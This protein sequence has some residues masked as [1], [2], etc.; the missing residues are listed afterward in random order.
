MRPARLILGAAGLAALGFGLTGLLTD[1]GVRLV[2][3]VPFL[4]GLVLLHDL[5]LLPVAIGIGVL[6]ARYLPVWARPFVQG[7]LF[8]SAAVT[9]FAL[10]FVIGAGRTA[11]NP[12]RFPRPY[13]LGLAA[14]LAVVWLVVAGLVLRARPRR[15]TVDA[16]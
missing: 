6:L 3:V 4:V 11:D 10:P 12:S 2:G 9:A 16:S 1:D 14:T 13:G 8:V 7:G 5:V 15:S